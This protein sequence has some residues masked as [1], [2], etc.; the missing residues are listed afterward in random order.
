MYAIVEAA[1]R[2]V[3]VKPG[4]TVELD[5]VDAP[6]GSDVVFDR[7]L[8]VGGDEVAVGRP[9]VEG[10]SVLARVLSHGRGPKKV[11]FRYLHRRRYRVRRGFRA[12]VTR[13][14]ILQIAR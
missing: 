6:V 11:S 2:Q 13:L 4:E 7:V 12:D 8:L 10:A 9:Y 5:H 3:H 14:E 1:G